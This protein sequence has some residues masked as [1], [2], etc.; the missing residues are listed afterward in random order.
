VDFPLRG[1]DLA[2]FLSCA[3]QS[4]ATQSP[5]TQ[6]PATPSP[7][8][9]SVLYDLAAVVHHAGSLRKGHYSAHVSE[10]GRWF[11]CDDEAVSAAAES[12]VAAAALT[13]TPYLLFYLRRKYAFGHAAGHAAGQGLG[14]GSENR[15]PLDS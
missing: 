14:Q 11:R 3:Q 1:L 6:C 10:G 7:V 4:P 13:G 2:P 5:E 15:A 12:D 8:T 9:P